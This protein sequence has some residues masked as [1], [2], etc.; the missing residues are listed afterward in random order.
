MLQ[1]DVIAA[2]VDEEAAHADVA[3]HAAPSVVAS[4]TKPA[5]LAEL[6]FQDAV[7][8]MWGTLDDADKRVQW[9]DD[10]FTLEMQN[11]GRGSRARASNGRS[12]CFSFD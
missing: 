12:F 7:D 9:G 8:L 4:A 1:L 2:A 5:N 10:G 11:K 3:E 6:S